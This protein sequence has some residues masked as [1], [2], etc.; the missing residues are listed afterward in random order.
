[1]R[2]MSGIM[3]AFL[4]GNLCLFLLSVVLVDPH[5]GDRLAEL[6]QVVTMAGLG[7]DTFGVVQPLLD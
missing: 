1:M 7:L 5:F 2:P 6:V 3:L 4:S